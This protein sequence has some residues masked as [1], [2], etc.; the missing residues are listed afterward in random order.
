LCA[1]IYKFFSISRCPNRR[2][3]QAVA[4]AS[5]VGYTLPSLLF[6]R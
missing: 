3:V 4:I 5:S 1:Q 2:A 6:L